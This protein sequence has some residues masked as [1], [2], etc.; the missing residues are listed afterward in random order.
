MVRIISIILFLFS[1]FAHAADDK[2]INLNFN[3]VS[4]AELTQLFVK[5]ILK[6][7][8]VI[9]N[10][11]LADTR[12]VTLSIQ[13]LKPDAA[14]SFFRDFLKTKGISLTEKNNIIYVEQQKIQ[15][16]KIPLAAAQNLPLTNSPGQT[17]DK[18]KNYIYSLKNVPITDLLPIFQSFGIEPKFSENGNFLTYS[19]IEKTNDRLNLLLNQIDKKPA[20]LLIQAFV[21][22]FAK[23]NSSSNSFSAAVSLLN[24]KFN[25]NITNN[26]KSNSVSV[27]F[28]DFKSVISA[29]DA[30]SR[31]T[32]ISNP[33]LRVTHNKI[34]KFSVG[35]ETPVLGSI[36]SNQNGQTQQSVTYRPSGVIFEVKPFIYNDQINLDINQQVSNFVLTQTGVNDSPTLI[37][38]ELQTNISLNDGEIVLLGGLSDNKENQ[39]ESGLN[40]LPSFFKAKNKDKTQNDI[41][42]ILQIQKL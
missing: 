34:S 30:D 12:K 24:S 31:F 18:S 32:V 33:F 19:T 5:G 28:P 13:S 38:R 1:T 14:Q 16:I 41:F 2:P 9:N 29:I 21:Y 27:N 7:D 3:S 35:S 15:E 6:K 36:V 17:E 25:I 40:F 10:D 8:Y 42:L 22:E 20:Q 23:T 37:K 11:V 4:I 39:D 26:Q